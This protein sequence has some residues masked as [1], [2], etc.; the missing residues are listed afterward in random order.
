MIE[1]G[2]FREDLYYRISEISIQIPALREREGEAGV[3]ANY[4]LGLEVKQQNKDHLVLSKD[5]CDAID[6]YPWPG[7]VRELANRIKRAVIMVDG[8]QIKAEDLELSTTEEAEPLPLNLRVV[9]EKAECSV[10]LRAL[11]HSGGNVSQAA[12][13]LGITRPTFYALVKRYKL[14]IGQT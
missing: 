2:T 5:A 8:K 13:L 11:N 10:L 7:N 9:R 3:L 6:A 1:Q 14:D 12:Q 4:F